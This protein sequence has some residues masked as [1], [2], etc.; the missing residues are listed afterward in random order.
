M[1]RV[2]LLGAFAIDLDG[3]VLLR[4]K[5]GQALIAYLALQPGLHPRE[6]LAALLWPDSDDEA[7]RQSLRQCLSGL[8][9]DLAALPLTVEHD[10]IGLAAPIASGVEE[11]T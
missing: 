11:L 9:K 1:F 7:A 3:P 8:R 5:K 10:V 4:N 2:R 6:K